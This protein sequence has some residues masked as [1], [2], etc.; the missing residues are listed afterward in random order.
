MK[1]VRSMG[2]LNTSTHCFPVA[3][4]RSL[5][6][7]Y[8]LFFA[9]VCQFAEVEASELD[10]LVQQVA[11]AN[12]AND[13]IEF[14]LAWA[15]E[16]GESA[17]AISIGTVASEKSRADVMRVVL[18]SLEALSRLDP[19][20]QLIVFLS[21]GTEKLLA[22]GTV[23][24]PIAENVRAGKPMPAWRLLIEH[25]VLP[26]GNKLELPS[27]LLGA[28]TT[29][30]KAIELLYPSNLT[31][32]AS[33]SSATSAQTDEHAGATGGS[34]EVKEDTDP[35]TDKATTQA[36]LKAENGKAALIV[37]C[38]D[39]SVRVLIFWNDYLAD[40]TNVTTRF[41]EAAPQTSSWAGSSNKRA[42]FVTDANEAAFLGKLTTSTKLIARI[43]PYNEGPRTEIFSLEGAA[44]ALG[45]LRPDC[46]TAG[47]G[48]RASR[49]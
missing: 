36:L 49:W 21:E 39:G 6:V 47:R 16:Y 37:G 44:E 27:S 42:T 26:D 5:T 45:N 9:G 48:N 46:P 22:E 23:L 30:L 20:P 8:V 32:T 33:G 17:V 19:Q 34:W 1:T 25:A 15:P 4:R 31:A 35:I 40:N 3:L 2:R 12:P 38:K 24:E 28:T 7:L 41:D 18:T 43:T 11:T 10:D 13:G 14:R 29:A